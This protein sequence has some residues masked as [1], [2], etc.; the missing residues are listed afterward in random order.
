M[1][2]RFNAVWPSI[3]RGPC[4]ASLI[5]GT[6]NSSGQIDGGRRTEV[7]G[8]KLSWRHNHNHL[9]AFKFGKKLDF[10]DVLD[11]DLNFF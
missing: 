9:T 10:G 5:P 2:I 7:A 3:G 4:Q 8:A 1:E 6:C 11:F